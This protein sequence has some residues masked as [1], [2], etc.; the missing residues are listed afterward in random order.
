MTGIPEDQPH[1]NEDG[2]ELEQI[3]DFM[4]VVL[5]AMDKFGIRSVS[6]SFRSPDSVSQIVIRTWKQD[7]GEIQQ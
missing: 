7:Q 1:P 4:G 5:Q 6:I 3:N 2:P